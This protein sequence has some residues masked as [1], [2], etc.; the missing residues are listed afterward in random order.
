MDL[1]FRFLIPL[2]FASLA[3]AAVPSVRVDF[4][5]ATETH[6]NLYGRLKGLL[7]RPSSPPFDPTNVLGRYVLGPRRSD[8]H[9][10]PLGW[11]MVHIVGGSPDEKTTLAIANDDL[12]LLGFANRTDNWHILSGFGG[13]PDATTLPFDESYGKLIG[14]HAN[15]CLVPI[16][17]QS[18][19]QAVKTLS[20]YDPATGTEQELKQA[21]VRFALMISEAMRF[22][23][24]RQSFSGRW[25]E[26]TLITRDQADYVVHWGQLSTLLVRHSMAGQILS[27]VVFSE[28]PRGRGGGDKG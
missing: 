10:V 13:L 5:L 21:L 26:T 6:S 14:G 3:Q 19:I 24:I 27:E 25:E 16:G 2:A 7:K 22:L 8:F 17:K 23:N 20:S 9:G 1:C 28:E 15:L 4:N 18:V 12:Y 11:I